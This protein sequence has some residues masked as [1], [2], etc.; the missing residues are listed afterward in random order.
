MLFL[1]KNLLAGLLNLVVH[2]ALHAGLW[3]KSAFASDPAHFAVVISR[4]ML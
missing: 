2:S 1:R 4:E 3:L